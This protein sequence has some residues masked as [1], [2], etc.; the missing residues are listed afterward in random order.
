[1]SDARFSFQND[2]YYYLGMEYYPGGSL[3]AKITSE[4][5][6]KRISL[7]VDQVQFYATQ[8]ILAIAHLHQHHIVYR[9]VVHS[10]NICNVTLKFRDLK[11]DNI[12]IDSVGYVVLLDFGLAKRNIPDGTNGAKTMA[13]SPGYTAPEI[14]NPSEFRCYGTSIDWWCL[15]VLLYELLYGKR[16]FTHPNPAMLYRKIQR[17]NVE[18]PPVDHSSKHYAQQMQAQDLIEKLLTKQPHK[19]LGSG[20]VLEIQ[21]HDFFDGIHWDLIEKRQLPAPSTPTCHES[22]RIQLDERFSQQHVLSKVVHRVIA[23]FVSRKSSAST[24][25]SDQFSYVRDSG[26]FC[27]TNENRVL[28]A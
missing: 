13:G 20:G 12:V 9:Y 23:K 28:S 16:P 2:K 26:L 21:S 25:C 17:N 22:T 1:M 27:D 10:F 19:R 5:G 11:P 14:L 3:Y 8:I 7:P 24:V 6:V 4:Y 15:G 18:F